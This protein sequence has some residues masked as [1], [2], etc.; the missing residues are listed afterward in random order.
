MGYHEYLPIAR[1]YGV[2]LVVTG[3]EPLDIVQ[4]ILVAVR[5]LEEGSA[6]VKNAYTRVVSQ[7]GNQT[8]QAVIQQVFMVCDRKWRGIGLIP[9]SGWCLRPKLS[10]FDAEKRF[11]VTEIQPEEPLVCIAGQILQGLQKPPHCPAFGSA[12]TPGHP[13]GATMV[14]GEGACAAYYSYGG[15]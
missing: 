7:A 15:K 9:A 8:A 11:E 14:S 12:C 3:F 1:H 5:Q 13:L 4:G 6:E 2:P 10:S